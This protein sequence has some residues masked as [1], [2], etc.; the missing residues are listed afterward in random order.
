MMENNIENLHPKGQAGVELGAIRS[1]AELL[2][3]ST[4]ALLQCLQMY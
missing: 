2:D 4:M 3:H 1:P